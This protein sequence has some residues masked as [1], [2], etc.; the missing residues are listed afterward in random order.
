MGS[1]DVAD[2]SWQTPTAQIRCTTYPAN[3]PGHSWQ[4]VSCGNSTIGFKGTINAGKVIA[5]S[6]IDIFINPDVLIGAKEEFEEKT[7]NGYL[8]P[9][10]DGVP[11]T[12]PGQ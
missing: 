7:V 8:C 11:P 1:T 2:V 5:A 12:I 10:P 6:A 3:S 9:I 4:N